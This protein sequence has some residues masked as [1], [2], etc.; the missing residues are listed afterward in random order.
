MCK[1]CEIENIHR[2]SF[3][4]SRKPQNV[5]FYRAFESRVV[6]FKFC[7]LHTRELFLVGEERFIENHRGILRAQGMPSSGDDD[8]DF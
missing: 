8:D 1:V 2:E 5:T 3:E 7:Y 4:G 6:K